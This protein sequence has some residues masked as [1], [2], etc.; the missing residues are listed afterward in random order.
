MREIVKNCEA[1]V[2]NRVDF[3]IGLQKSWNS[4][5]V[6]F[7]WCILLLPSNEV[8]VRIGAC[9]VLWNMNGDN[10]SKFVTTAYAASNEFQVSLMAS[11]RVSTHF[12]WKHIWHEN[13][14]F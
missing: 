9:H 4:D 8:N 11:G 13:R 14:K 1:S 12:F 3:I 7:I 6:Y 10:S 2:E 5:S